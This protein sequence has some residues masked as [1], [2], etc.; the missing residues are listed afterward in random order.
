M[1]KLS[2]R[3]NNLFGRKTPKQSA[4]ERTWS[5]WRMRHNLAQDTDHSRVLE[6]EQAYNKHTKHKR[7]M[8]LMPSFQKMFG[9][10]IPIS[11]HISIERG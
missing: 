10:R 9:D 11:E 4:S 7:M 3:W 8:G 1:Q 2:K 6:A 5:R